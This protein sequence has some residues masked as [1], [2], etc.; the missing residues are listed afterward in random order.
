MTVHE[1]RGMVTGDYVLPN[2][3][4]PQLLEKILRGRDGV[5]LSIGSFRG[6]FAAAQ[7]GAFSHLISI[8]YDRTVTEF[9]RAHFSFARDVA[10]RHEYLAA[11][12]GRDAPELVAQA[13]AGKLTDAEFLNKLFKVKSS[14]P[15]RSESFRARATKAIGW[16]WE[17]LRA[18]LNGALDDFVTYPERW[19][20][21]FFGS[22]ELFERFRAGAADGRYVALNANIGNV[23]IMRELG[24]A[25][26]ASNERVSFVDLSNVLDHVLVNGFSATQVVDALSEL[27]LASDC[28]VVVTLQEWVNN[29]QPWKY[30]VFPFRTLVQAREKGYLGDLRG[31]L[32]FLKAIRGV[33]PPGRGLEKALFAAPPSYEL[34]DQLPEVGFLKR[35]MRFL[36]GK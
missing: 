26:R 14:G 36:L 2:E 1:E 33:A 31:Y 10:N 13:R 6:V 30:H 24:T 29:T 7:S 23:E 8:D 17:E 15:P 34:P 16:D 32:K 28:Q 21:T 4:D 27:P 20:A 19:K 3:T 18:Q 11:I 22:D 35:C 12:Y 9:N 5:A 25:L